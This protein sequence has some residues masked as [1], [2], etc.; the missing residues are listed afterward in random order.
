MF[1]FTGST[2]ARWHPA[3]RA[4]G[5][6]VRCTAGNLAESSAGDPIAAM[7]ARAQRDGW[8]YREL[9]APHDPQLTDPLGT[10]SILHDLGV[11][12]AVC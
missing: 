10:A 5:A 4:R 6:Y 3:R 2:Y 7:A 12:G 9:T 11:E 8:L 1:A